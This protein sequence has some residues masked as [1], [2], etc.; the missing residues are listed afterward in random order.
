[1]AVGQPLKEEPPMTFPTSRSRP[2]RL[3]LAALALLASLVA[4]GAARPALAGPVDK[5]IWLSLSQIQ[6]L[7]TS[8]SAWNAVK[9][10]AD[11]SLGTPNIADQD[12][13]HDVNTLAAALVYAR[14]SDAAYRAKAANAILGAIGTEAGGRT[15]AL[16]RN[17]VSYVIAADLVN[18]REYDPA[19]DARFRTWLASVRREVL[20]GKTLVQTHEQ[21][22]NNWGTHAGASRIAADAYLGDFSDLARAATVFRGW[23]GDRSAYSGFG[24]GDLSWQSN[25]SAPVGI[26]PAGATIQGHDV[27]GVLPDDQR[28]AGSFT[29][30]AP[31]ENYVWGALGAAFLQATLLQRAGYQDAF[32]WSDG[33]LRRAVR[34]LYTVD[35][36]PPSGDDTWQPWLINRVLGTTYPA[37]P[38]SKGKA[39]AWTDWMF[40]ATT[41]STTSTTTTTTSTTST[42]ST[43]GS[44]TGTS[45]TSTGGT[46]TGTTGTSGTTSS[47]GGTS[48]GTG[49]P[50]VFRAS[51]DG[52]VKSSSPTKSYG[53]DTFLRVRA[54]DP[55]H[56]SYVAFTVTGLTAAPKSAKLRLYVTDPSDDGGTVYAVPATWTETGLTW[57]SAPPIGSVA[58]GRLAAPAANAW[59]ELDLGSLVTGNGTYALAVVSSS[60]NSAY[61][62]SREGVNPPQLVVTQ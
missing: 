10:A 5:G 53:S 36:F 44:T 20:D 45:G 6:A 9:A 37:G 23:L 40:G 58:L 62:S 18:L 51:A 14:T 8:G 26:N 38:A 3:A 42:T 48:T 41:T 54:G 60:S 11:G 7:P 2:R 19:G 59:A 33:A 49:S 34:W 50:L 21:R 56:R 16:G 43:S 12:S 35:S 31:K 47:T 27:D 57:S 1:M 15:L 39:M 28:R 46:T 61:Y 13:N 55:E 25:P 32:S 22:A 17:L 4:L 29:W 24:F 30:P 52:F